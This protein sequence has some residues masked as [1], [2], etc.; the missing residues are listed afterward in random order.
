VVSGGEL[1]TLSSD[2]A[3]VTINQLVARAKI[4]VPGIDVIIRVPPHVP[5]FRAEVAGLSPISSLKI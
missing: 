4:A 1:R 2:F 5:P 3:E